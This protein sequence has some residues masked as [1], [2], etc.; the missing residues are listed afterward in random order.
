MLSGPKETVERSRRL[1]REMSLPEVLLWRELRQRP[2]GFKFRKQHPAGRFSAD[3]FC[4]QA[5]LV[6]EVDG[7]AH[8]RGDNPARD[9]SRDKWFGERGFRVLRLA[10]RDVL[11]NLDGAIQA[12]VAEARTLTPLHRASRGPPPLEGEDFGGAPPQ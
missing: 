2:G 4:H 3:F 8:N 9:V 6:V 11:G 12:I 5:R 7:E 1:R 10:A